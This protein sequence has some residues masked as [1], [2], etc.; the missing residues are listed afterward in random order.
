MPPVANQAHA[1]IGCV[2]VIFSINII[3]Q[4]NQ[5]F[6]NIG[7]ASCCDHIR[8]KC[9]WNTRVSLRLLCEFGEQV[10]DCPS[11]RQHAAYSCACNARASRGTPKRDES[12]N[13]LNWAFSR[14]C[15]PLVRRSVQR[16]RTVRAPANF[17]DPWRRKSPQK[18]Y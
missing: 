16:G 3:M 1:R 13:A 4:S 12:K 11:V 10:P 9:T 18:P 6:K 17:E 8:S 2:H 14:C 7:S 5:P 15:A